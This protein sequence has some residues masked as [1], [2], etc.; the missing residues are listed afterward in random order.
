M[1]QFLESRCE[2]GNYKYD[3]F[4]N[5]SIT[6]SEFDPS[7]VDEKYVLSD[8]V[9][10]YVL[11]PGTKSFKT[12]IKYDLD[13]ARTVLSTMGNRHRAGVDNYVTVDGKLRRLTPRECLRLMGFG[14]DFK[15]VVSDTQLYHQ[16][17]NSIVSD[18]FI[19]LFPKISETGVFE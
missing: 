6:E 16:A 19:R 13:V 12:S 1:K 11:T 14:D 10:K 9:R 17:G 15:Q 2:L 18:I 5:I 3:E 8:L 7:R 4:G